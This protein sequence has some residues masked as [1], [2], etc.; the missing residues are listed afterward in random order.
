MIATL[1]TALALLTGGGD[2]L[3]DHPITGQPVKPTW[4]YSYVTTT[5]DKRYLVRCHVPVRGERR[6]YIIGVR[7]T[8]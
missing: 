3:P 6:C 1:L 7:V 4:S 2:P 5:K 8:P